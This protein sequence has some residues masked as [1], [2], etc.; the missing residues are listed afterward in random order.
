MSG[1]AQETDKLD[2]VREV[3]ES[4]AVKKAG[5]M[6]NALSTG[7]IAHL[8]E[9]V[10]PA[11][12][13]LLWNL[14]DQEY[15]GEILVQVTDDVRDDLIRQM[16]RS[17]LLSATEGLD[18]D[19]LADLIENLP[20]TITPEVLSSLDSQHRKRLEAVLSYPEDTAGHLMN[21]DTVTIRPEVTLDVV[22][23]Y[24]RQLGDKVP[25]DTD[26]LIVVNRQDKYLGTLRLSALVSNDTSESVAEIM[27]LEPQPILATMPQTEVAR[28][29][30]QLDLISAPVVNEEGLLL[31]R[32]TIDDIVDVIREEGEHQFMGQ[33]GLS[34]DEDMFAPVMQSSRRRALWLG[35]NLVT[36]LLASW[37]IGQF[38]ATIDK[39]VALAVLMPIVA[40]M[41]GIAGSQTLALTIRGLALGQL[42][43]SNR[44][45]LIL[46][47]LAVGSINSLIWAIV[48]AVVAGMWFDS[49][50]LSI[51]IGVAMTVNLV[52]ASIMGTVLPMLLH[53]IGI[54]PALAGSVVL[55]TVTDIV[56][57]FAFLG[58]ATLFLV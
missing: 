27:S 34:E 36:A 46:K 55:T 56:G 21:I 53:H 38:E 23:R 58:L 49:L 8:L 15:D 25:S 45:W 39:V 17:E 29:F 3:L 32:I 28:Q 31:G 20:Y 13:T 9:S 35:I 47:E 37:V 40:S 11:E 7:E 54:D 5:R 51:L 50:T 16:D 12:R 43:G 44:R 14:V 42:S 30:E 24:L 10:P 26:S 6:I 19:D 33:A 57:F 4:G 22:L 1:E 2:R 48:V 18:I 52:I 41:G